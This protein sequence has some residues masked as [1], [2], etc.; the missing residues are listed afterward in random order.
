VSLNKRNFK[1]TVRNR[2][3]LHVVYINNIFTIACDMSDLNFFSKELHFNG[4]YNH[5]FS[6]YRNGLMQICT[7]FYY[8]SH[9]FTTVDLGR[10]IKRQHYKIRRM[11]DDERCKCNTKSAEHWQSGPNSRGATQRGH[12]DS[13]KQ[14]M[15]FPLRPRHSDHCDLWVVSQRQVDFVIGENVRNYQQT[16]NNVSDKETTIQKI[17]SKCATINATSNGK[18]VPTFAARSCEGRAT[19]ISLLR[20]V[21]HAY[22]ISGGGGDQRHRRWLRR[23]AGTGA[24]IADSSNTDGDPTGYPRCSDIVPQTNPIIVILTQP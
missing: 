5:F 24:R 7:L 17:T 15:L 19:V 20:R 2:Y 12:S 6:F 3:R 22:R 8:T 9:Y 14:T 23:T 10:A 13:F 16:S 21:R 4:I 1:N 11:C 18:L